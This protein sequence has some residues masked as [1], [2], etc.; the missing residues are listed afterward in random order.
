[1]DWKLRP[2]R[3]LGLAPGDRLR[4]LARER[5][6]FGVAANAAWRWLLR[7][8]FRVFHRLEVT[9]RENLPAAPFVLI[10]N[11]GSH[12]DALV[13]AA[14]LRGEAGR[15]AH[16]LAAGEVFFGSGAGAA[17]AAY[18]INAMPI[19]RG[20]TQ[21]GDIRMLRERLV[22]D[23][24]VYILFPEGTRSRS[25][26]MGEFQPGLAALVAGTGVAVVPCW[27]EGA[28]AAWPPQRRW[29]RPGKLRLRIGAPLSM[30]G[31]RAAFTAACRAA[32]A[33][34]AAAR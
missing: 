7:L 20:K 29:P 21:R 19:W 34:L 13:L 30:E 33:A 25:G 15:A 14:S 5:G 31:D 22:E 28:H 4:S 24:L 16:A 9:G 32:V 8:Y 11:H 12:L 26:E 3:D 17:F 1:M 18:A 27:I 6:L 23:R 2:A 10:A